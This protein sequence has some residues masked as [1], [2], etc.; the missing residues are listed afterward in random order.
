MGRM[1]VAIRHWQIIVAQRNLRLIT[2]RNIAMTFCRFLKYL[3]GL[4]T[5][6]GGML[7]VLSVSVQRHACFSIIL[8]RHKRKKNDKVNVNSKNTR[9]SSIF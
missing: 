4:L 6:L 5:I 3:R 2:W 1:F 9:H 7:I 8:C